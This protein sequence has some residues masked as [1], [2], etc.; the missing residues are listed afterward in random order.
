MRHE[1]PFMLDSSS[2]HYTGKAGSEF[3]GTQGVTIMKKWLAVVGIALG[4]SAT[5]VYTADKK[6]QVKDLPAAVQKTVQEQTKDATLVGVSSEKEGGKTV[7]ELE[8]KA[9]GKTRDLLIDAAGKVIEVEQEVSIDS[10]PPAV[11]TALEARGKVL[12]V[13]TLTKGTTVSYE[14]QIENKG[15]KS[16][17]AVDGNG[18]APKK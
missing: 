14:A 13:E 10:V 3:T 1:P 5:L 11:K 8:T 2:A 12:K 18:K 7:Y 6:L 15:K 9:N 4:V 16:E 17:V